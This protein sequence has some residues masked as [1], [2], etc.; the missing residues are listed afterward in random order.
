[1][2][3]KNVK[4]I[5]KMPVYDITVNSANYDDQHYVLENGVITHNTGAYYGADNI[6]IIGR[7]QEKV[8]NEI[9]GYHFVINIE[10][11]RYVKEKAKIPITVSFDGGINRWSGLLDVALHGNYIDKPKNGWYAVVDQT[12]GELKTP[13]MRASDII[14]N[15]EFWLK[16]FKETDFASFIEKEYKFSSG[17][18]M[19]Y[20]EESVDYNTTPITSEKEFHK[21][22]SNL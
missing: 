4:K 6:W 1:M 19:E 13:N 8:D 11:S 14:D 7:Q 12:T 22:I 9:A 16:M 10:K 17:A 3:I 5:G 18:M 2:K 20:D 15:K 21:P